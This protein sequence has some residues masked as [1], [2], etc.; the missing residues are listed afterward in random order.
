VLA[1]AHAPA[2][3]VLLRAVLELLGGGGMQGI[4][5]AKPIVVAVT[6]LL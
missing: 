2:L 5:P 1:T 4:S 6:A 3:H